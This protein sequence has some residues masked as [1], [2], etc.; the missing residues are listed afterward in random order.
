MAGNVAQ[1]L[2]TSLAGPRPRAPSSAQEKEKKAWT[3][4][5]QKQHKHS[6]TQTFKILSA[7]EQ[8]KTLDYSIYKKK[9]AHSIAKVCESLFIKE[10]RDKRSLRLPGAGLNFP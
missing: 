8:G 1:R 2:G 9:G 5:Q 10:G 3:G 6:T 7:R 4:T